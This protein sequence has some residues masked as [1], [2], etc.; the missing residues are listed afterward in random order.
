MTFYTT[1][2]S[3]SPD[4]KKKMF[5]PDVMSL[6]IWPFDFVGIVVEMRE[7]ADGCV[8]G[9]IEWEPCIADVNLN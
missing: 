7:W 8:Y 5:L 9:V 2:M 4:K 3:F 1:E 6:S